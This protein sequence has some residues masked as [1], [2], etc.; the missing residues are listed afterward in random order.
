MTKTIS[1]GTVPRCDEFKIMEP[2]NLKNF[3]DIIISNLKVTGIISD[4]NNYITPIDLSSSNNFKL[5]VNDKFVKLTVSHNDTSFEVVYVTITYTFSKA[6]LIYGMCP[7]PT[8]MAL[9]SIYGK[10]IYELPTKVNLGIK[11]VIFNKPA[12][13][14]LWEDGSKTVVK[15]NKGDKWDPEKGLAMAI[16]KKKFGLKEF[17]KYV[18]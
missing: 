18:E 15:L 8:K 13:I 16:I 11:K 14:V 7:M 12:T 6:D 3:D 1:L 4:S 5:I 2:H 9:N 10:S 17:F